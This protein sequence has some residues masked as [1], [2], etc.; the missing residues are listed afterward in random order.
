MAKFALKVKWRRGGLGY[1]GTIKKSHL[2]REI[3]YA[4]ARFS[5]RNSELVIVPDGEEISHSVSCGE[6]KTLD[7]EPALGIIERY[8]LN[9]VEIAKNRRVDIDKGSIKGGFVS[10]W[11]LFIKSKNDHPPDHPK[12]NS[13]IYFRYETIHNLRS[14]ELRDAPFGK[15]GTIELN[16]DTFEK[17][18]EGVFLNSEMI[19]EKIKEFFAGQNE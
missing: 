4:H 1:F 14:K 10:S 6:L 8:V 17:D 11:E 12:S 7:G 16:P 5:M 3:K 19:V 13:R 2:T 18:I 15:K 9:R